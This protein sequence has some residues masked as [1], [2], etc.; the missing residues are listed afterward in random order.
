MVSV[1]AKCHGKTLATMMGL[2]WASTVVPLIEQGVIVEGELIQIALE[3]RLTPSDH[4]SPMASLIIVLLRIS[5]GERGT[6]GLRE[7]SAKRSL[8]R[9]VWTEESSFP[10]WAFMRFDV[11]LWVPDGSSSNREWN[12]EGQISSSS[13]VP[14]SGES[15]RAEY[16][17]MGNEGLDSAAR[18]SSWVNSHSSWRG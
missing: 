5:A 15:S 6:V 3:K 8:D 9:S 4:S 18:K 17:D 11:Y 13:D 12:F 2:M 14:G 10:T 1:Y 16:E 7:G